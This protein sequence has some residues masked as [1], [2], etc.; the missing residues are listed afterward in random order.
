M[1]GQNNLQGASDAGLI[2]M[3]RPNYQRVDNAGVHGWFERYRGDWLDDQPGYTVVEV[4]TKAL[5]G[6]D[7]P[8]RVRGMVIMG[9][10]PALSDPDL[11]HA[12]A[13]LDPFGK[14]PELKCCAVRVQRG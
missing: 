11:S 1:R 14:I 13:A 7:D 3:M 9:E 4:M 5:A 12:R 2:P 8:H 10:N 6:D